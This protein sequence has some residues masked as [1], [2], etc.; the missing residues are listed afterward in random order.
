M[1]TRSTLLIF[2]LLLITSDQLL[3][4]NINRNSHY[5]WE[6]WDDHIF[7][8]MDESR[9]MVEIDYGIGTFEHND[10]IGEFNEVGAIDFKLGYSTIDI[11][12]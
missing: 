10:L 5:E 1:K 3:A 6:D 9:P 4:Q 7:D 12:G 2:L 8:W 11:Y